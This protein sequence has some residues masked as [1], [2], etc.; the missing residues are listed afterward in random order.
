MAT[1]DYIQKRV[2]KRKAQEQSKADF[3]STPTQD[4]REQGVE[5]FFSAPT[6]E[7]K[8]EPTPAPTTEREAFMSGAPT[9]A[10]DEGKADAYE[11]SGVEAQP[12]EQTEAQ[13]EPRNMEEKPSPNDIKVATPVEPPKNYERIMQL[14]D[15]DAP[16]SPK[17]KEAEEKRRKREALF[18][19]LGDG[20]SSLANVY[21]A[22][23]G[24]YDMSG[25]PSQS[26][27]ARAKARWDKI[28][29]DRE[30]ADL[31][32]YQRIKEREEARRQREKEIREYDLEKEKLKVDKQQGEALAAY[33]DAE[34][35]RKAEADALKAEEQKRVNN[36]RIANY[37][38][39][40]W[41]KYNKE[42]DTNKNRYPTIPIHLSEE[43][44]VDVDARLMKDRSVVNRL[45]SYLTDEEQQSAG[46]YNAIERKYEEPSLD[47]M[48]QAI[49]KAMPNNKAMQAY[50]R[51][52]TKSVPVEEKTEE[53]NAVKESPTSNVK[54]PSPTSNGK[55]ESPTKK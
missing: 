4:N 18:S 52:L 51:S 34:T 53:T 45:F 55:K 22:S 2:Q 47:Q 7:V 26:L 32:F 5:S 20:L 1:K 17:E 38:A 41:S 21:F 9:S 46:G 36:A 44:I 37:N 12:T 15:P 19:A 3:Y 25:D 48:M 23:E 16:L 35:K 30:A 24:A 54:K 6:T 43:E 49:F 39:N 29:A 33:R 50:V 28:Q 27:S 13:A 40:T 10:K 14:T 42:S 31:R 8:P 11:A